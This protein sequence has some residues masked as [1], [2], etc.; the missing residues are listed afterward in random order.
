MEAV[1]WQQARHQ[2]V[3]RSQ[4]RQARHPFVSRVHRQ[5][6]C[7]AH[8]VSLLR[9]QTASV[10]HTRAGP[11]AVPGAPATRLAAGERRR[12]K[13]RASRPA[14]L[15]ARRAAPPQGAALPHI[16]RR[17]PCSAE[18][19]PRRTGPGRAQAAWPG[20]SRPPPPVSPWPES[21]S[22]SPIRVAPRSDRARTPAPSF[23]LPSCA[24][25]PMV[26]HGLVC[27]LD[28]RPSNGRPSDGR[29][30]FQHPPP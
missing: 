8:R 25:H 10:W 14:A 22:D 15:L 5:S 27:A 13:A 9:A 21:D 7:G 12:A 1:R 18:A 26:G 19:G 20:R 16:P 24:D 29:I 17:R 4:M 2:S 3:S 30:R 23:R 28:G 11:A 6:L